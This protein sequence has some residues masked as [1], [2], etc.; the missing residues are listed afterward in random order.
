MTI[1][2]L[3]IAGG[4]ASGKTTATKYLHKHGAVILD[5]DVIARD[6]TSNDH[7]IIASIAGKFGKGILYPD[8]SLNRAKIRN[9]IFNDLDSKLWLEELLHPI[10]KAKLLA[11]KSAITSKSCIIAL[12][13]LTASSKESYGIDM[14]CTIVSDKNL[15]I[16]RLMARDKITKK[17][18]EIIIANQISD[19]ELIALSDKIITNN[20]SVDLLYQELKQLQNLIVEK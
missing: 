16:S 14:I 13:L 19:E 3:A 8:G 7:E 10:I 15:R 1:F 11:Q 5:A 20:A 18:A 4:I 2:T 17:E 9:I 12:P 6:I